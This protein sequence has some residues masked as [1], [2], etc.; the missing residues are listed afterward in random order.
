MTSRVRATIIA[1]ILAASGCATPIPPSGG[2]PD[3]IPP[4]IAEMTP[5][6][7]A[8]NVDTEAVRF[9]FSEY[10]DPASFAQ[11][12]SISPSFDRPV[13]FRWSRRTVDIRFPEPLRENTTY[14]L[15]IDT[16]LLDIHRVALSSP[17]I[18]AFSTGP[19]ISAGVLSGRVV[20]G[21]DGTPVPGID[22]LAYAR[23]DSTA[24]DTLDSRPAY[25]TQTNSAGIF[26]FEYLTEQFYFVPA[27]RDENRNLRPDA[28]EPF[29]TP[30]APAFFADTTAETIAHPFI[31]AEID[32]T[33]PTPLRA[34]SSARSHHLIRF[35]EPVRFLERN[36]GTWALTDSASG[37][38][39]DV[40]ILYTGESD[41]RQVS[42]ITEDLQSGRYGVVPAALA[43]TSG[44]VLASEPV[45]FTPTPQEDTL[46]TRFVEFLPAGPPTAEVI[47]LP[48]GVE[49]GLRFNRPISEEL[50]G[51]A[52]AVTDSTGAARGFIAVTENGTAYEIRTDPGL[53]PGDRISIAVDV[54]KLSGA[55]T[56]MSRSYRRIPAEETGE[57]A[58]VVRM[59]DAIGDT[60]LTRAAD[61]PVVVQ[62]FPIDV[63]M[64]VPTYT[65]GTDSAGSFLVSGLPAGSYRLRAFADVDSSGIWDPGLLMPYRPAEGVAW[66]TEAVRVRSR[67]ETALPDTLRIPGQR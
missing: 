18:Y 27:L 7:G 6:Q 21:R 11:A 64:V 43:D 58:G 29:A 42:F 10:V 32:T 45:Y 4:E 16:N 50:L 55:D 59:L 61:V 65:T 67:W 8:V 20:A 36:P 37:Q 48:R 41:P 23:P 1:L 28:Q 53:T 17:I 9:T 22:V 66:H 54:S 60:T 63:A 30:P 15:T 31:L 3:Q 38:A 47:L 46:Q 57:I 52:V 62:I 14:V 24:P 19:T 49:P 25:R 39:L 12:F 51:A 35:S 33:A 34:Q 40:H 26:S 2:P 5:P 13:D 44:N 56:T